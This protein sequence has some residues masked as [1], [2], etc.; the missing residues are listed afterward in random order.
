MM[1]DYVC[2]VMCVCR[3]EWSIGKMIK[4]YDHF[5]KLFDPSQVVIIEL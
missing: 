4:K 5:S 1:N 3:V 2:S